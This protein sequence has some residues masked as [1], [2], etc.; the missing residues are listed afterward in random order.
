MKKINSNFMKMKKINPNFINARFA[1]FATKRAFKQYRLFFECEIPAHKIRHKIKAILAK[2][3]NLLNVFKEILSQHFNITSDQDIVKNADVAFLVWQVIDDYNHC[4]RVYHLRGDTT[5]QDL[6]EAFAGVGKSGLKIGN[7]KNAYLE[8][9]C[10]D[11][12]DSNEFLAK[13]K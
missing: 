8:Q 2:D 3:D 7:L 6:T 10:K 11:F 13:F 12:S 5:A 9:R 1:V 4:Y